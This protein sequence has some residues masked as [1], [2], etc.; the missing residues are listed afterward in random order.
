MMLFTGQT[1]DTGALAFTTDLKEAQDRFVLPF[2]AYVHHLDH[3][4]IVD[5][6]EAEIAKL[7]EQNA[8]L[9]EAL[10]ELRKYSRH[11]A[12]CD[13]LNG[14]L[15]TC[16]YSVALNAYDEALKKVGVEG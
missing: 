10:K 9:I 4:E 11:N 3:I 13:A 14:D 1:K 12:S 5:K 16:G 6:L 8:I 2:T 15:C 7:K